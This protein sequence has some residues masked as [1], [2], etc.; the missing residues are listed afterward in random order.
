MVTI[1]NMG[2]A[3]LAL[4]C[5]AFLG[6]GCQPA[7]PSAL[8]EGERL[9][10]MNRPEAAAKQLKKAVQLLPREARAFNFL[11]VALHRSGQIEKA[12]DAYLEALDLDHTLTEARFNLGCLYVEA[13]SFELAIPMLEQYSQTVTNN[14]RAWLKLSEAYLGGARTEGERNGHLRQART[15]LANVLALTPGD[16]EALNFLGL[17]ELASGSAN[18]AHN[19][20]LEAY[21]ENPGFAPAL[22]N[23]GVVNQFHRNDTERALTAYKKYVQIS[24][25]PPNV[26]A[27]VGT[28]ESLLALKNLSQIEVDDRADEQGGGPQRGQAASQEGTAVELVSTREPLDGPQPT[29]SIN[30][31]GSLGA[32]ESGAGREGG[33]QT[34]AAEREASV[35]AEGVYGETSPG[36]ELAGNLEAPVERIDVSTDQGSESDKD[37]DVDPTGVV[38]RSGSETTLDEMDEGAPSN[39]EEQGP[40]SLEVTGVT[41]ATR[42]A[43]SEVVPVAAIDKDLPLTD[44]SPDRGELDSAEAEIKLVNMEAEESSPDASGGE[45]GV[46][47]APFALEENSLR[48]D[49]VEARL[50]GTDELVRES[51][52]ATPLPYRPFYRQYNYQY[53]A[54]PRRGDSVAAAPF[55]LKA[56][57]AQNDR[58]MGEAMQHYLEAVRL[59][60]SNF[61]VHY[62]LGVCAGQVG[63]KGRALEAYETALTIDPRSWQ[64]RYNFAVELDREG[65]PGTAVHEFERLLADQPDNIKAHFLAAQIY[66]EKLKLY[67]SAERHYRQ[68]LKLDAFHPQADYI[69]RWLSNRN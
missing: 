15:S 16:P 7:G 48:S 13:A 39:S 21:N 32:L 23:L 31:E 30:D 65:F 2:F 3:L 64:A 49:T 9:L 55:I 58:R 12:R 44:V 19:H 4:V 57:E 51:E 1:K 24:P 10:K 14:P 42:V 43:V 52:A 53:P 20:F 59:D 40:P 61:S 35:E 47:S 60:P 69:R 34:G 36:Q 63:E 66:R 33:E 29:E 67:P 41:E 37:S 38:Q 68:V 56:K 11:G 26:S 28:I 46:V 22:F 5:F 6:T 17:V 8:L 54:R 27:I 25:P 62:N 45:G 18:K 50:I